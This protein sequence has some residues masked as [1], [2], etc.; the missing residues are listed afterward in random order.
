MVPPDSRTMA[1]LN[2]RT[3]EVLACCSFCYRQGAEGG[4]GRR[5]DRVG[6]GITFKGR[7]VGLLR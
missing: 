2:V 7:L 4:V 6:P 1:R 3:V 5:L